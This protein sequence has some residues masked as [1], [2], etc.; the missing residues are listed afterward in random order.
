MN[1][2]T[3]LECIRNP[4]IDPGPLSQIYRDLGERAAEETICQALEDLAIR[5]NRLQDL[6]SIAGF[7]D[8]ARQSDRMAVIALGIGLTEVVTAARHVA[9]CARQ[10]DSVALEATLSR[11]ERGFDLAISQIWDIRTV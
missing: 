7:A 10:T 4:V 6:R 9:D 8:L 11:L 3:V 5:L 2:V 1:T